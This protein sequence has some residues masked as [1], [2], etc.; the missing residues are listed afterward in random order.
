M[1]EDTIIGGAKQAVGRVE[2]ATGALI[3]DPAT[4][5]SGAVRELGG[6]TQRAFGNA[7]DD[8]RGAVGNSRVAPFLAGIS[9]GLVVGLFLSR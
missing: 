6:A 4:E 2:R 9:L 7:K 8:V 5:I 1:D 3:A